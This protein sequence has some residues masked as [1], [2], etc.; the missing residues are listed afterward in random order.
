M[1][2]RLILHDRKE[3]DRRGHYADGQERYR[4][5]N[6][7]VRRG[8][9]VCKRDTEINQESSACNNG[10]SNYRRSREVQER[11]QTRQPCKDPFLANC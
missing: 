6:G 2:H 4:L 9:H 3:P 5:D 8:P 7:C 10:S 11:G 1:N